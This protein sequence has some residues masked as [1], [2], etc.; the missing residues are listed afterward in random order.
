MLYTL[1]KIMEVKLVREFILSE[2]QREIIQLEE[3][4][5][6]TSINNIAA[7]VTIKDNVKIEEIDKSLNNLIKR[8]ESYR[9]KVRKLNSE[10]KQ[11]IDEYKRKDFEY[12]DFYNNKKGYDEWITTQIKS[13][14]F[15]LN[16]E[17][18]KFVIL[19]QPSG[20]IGIL[21]LQH[22]F[23]S[24]G[25]SM[26]IAGNKLCESLI[27]GKK[28][29]NFE[30]TYLDHV[31]EEINY[32]NSSRFEKDKQFWLKKV[33][34]LE[35]NELFENKRTNSAQGHRLNYRLSD[36]YTH[37]IMD[38]CKSNQ[39][40]ISNLFSAAMLILKYKKIQ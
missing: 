20:D 2:A 5:E 23:I 13:N 3:Y 12:I 1:I 10:Y 31:E 9:I 8:H 38:F 40:S 17:L 29:A 4:Y 33:E 19:T 36:I 39:L 26:T 32:K 22:H 27:Y 28:E 18:F 11:Y 34:N 24:D 15:A 6:N 14:I 37:K 16:S 30:Y 25:W 7:I 35:N 21:L